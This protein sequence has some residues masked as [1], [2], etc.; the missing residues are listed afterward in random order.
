M[1]GALPICSPVT[2]LDKQLLFRT[3]ED[4]SDDKINGW[5]KWTKVHRLCPGLQTC[6]PEDY[7]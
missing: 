5:L 2:D 7:L 4:G 3:S 1:G 6:N